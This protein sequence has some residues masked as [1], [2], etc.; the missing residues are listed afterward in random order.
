MV[1]LFTS[2]STFVSFSFRFLFSSRF[3]CHRATPVG[4]P[5][6]IIKKLNQHHLRI[7]K[8]QRTVRHHQ[9]QKLKLKVRGKFSFFHVENFRFSAIKLSDSAFSAMSSRIKD[10]EDQENEVPR[11]TVVKP[12]KITKPSSNGSTLKQALQNV[13]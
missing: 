6:R 10:D 2:T 13:S 12:V 4:R 9:Y 5:S 1:S 8:R 11:E 7:R 3:Q